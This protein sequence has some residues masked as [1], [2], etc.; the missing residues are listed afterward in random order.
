MAKL[1]TIYAGKENP[2]LNHKS[3]RFILLHFG[4]GSRD[5]AQSA[6]LSEYHLSRVLCG[7][8]K[9][10]ARSTRKKLAA[11]LRRII[12]ADNVI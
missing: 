6:G 2:M 11:G 4:I 12:T 8:Q 10:I 1:C 5:L 7:K 9:R 3:L